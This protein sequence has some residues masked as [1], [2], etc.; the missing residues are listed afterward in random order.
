MV[1]PLGKSVETEEEEEDDG[2]PA[3]YTAVHFALSIEEWQSVAEAYYSD[4][5]RVQ[6]VRVSELYRTVCDNGAGVSSEMAMKITPWIGRRYF[7]V[8]PPDSDRSML[9]VPR[10]QLRDHWQTDN[11]RELVLYVPANAMM[12]VTRAKEVVTVG[13][14]ED[15]EMVDMRRD[16][17]LMCHDNAQHPGLGRTLAAIRSVAYWSTMAGNEDRDSVQKHI[18]MCAHCISVSEKVAEH[19]LGVDTVRRAEVI[20]IDHFILDDDQK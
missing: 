8:K 2:T 9:Y 4:E 7:S 16:L 20:Q 17:V 14:A 1:Y 18:S 6:S 12:R 15:Y 5:G 3:G 19:G 11:T 13:E 10:Q